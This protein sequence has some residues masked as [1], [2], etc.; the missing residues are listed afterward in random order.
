MSTAGP[1]LGSKDH[2]TGE[3]AMPTVMI[4]GASRGIGLELARQYAAAGWRV[5][6]TTRTPEQPGALGHIVGDVAVHALDV[7]NAPQIET[8]AHSLAHEGL[9]VLIHN[10]GV[11]GRGMD[12]DEV[13]RVNA[14]APMMVTQAL[15]PA[16]KRGQEK[17]I[18]LMTS[19]LGARRG[20]TRSL[21]IYGDSKAALN[22]AFRA[23]APAWG[24]AGLIAIVMH[25]GWVRTDMG[26]A[27]APLSV[28]KSVSGMRQ[29][30]A[31]L[32]SADHG[33]FWTWDGREHPW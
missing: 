11:S 30:I 3:D 28:Q 10:A 29:V 9:D 5:H 1:Y 14:E 18:V 23:H 17:K 20:S 13:M 7:R 27:G 22:D 2:T 32:T 31:R 25:P 8:L 15:L 26:G 6:A 19:Q 24:R 4:I 21:G 16:V 33:R 12:P